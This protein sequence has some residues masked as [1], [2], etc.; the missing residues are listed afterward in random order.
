MDAEKLKEICLNHIKW[1]NN[2]GGEKADLCG[3]NLC[4]ADLCINIYQLDLLDRVTI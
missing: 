3:A 2:D 1:L 4:G